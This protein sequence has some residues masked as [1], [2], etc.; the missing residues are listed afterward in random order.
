MVNFIRY[1]T[2]KLPGGTVESL[3]KLS[4]ILWIKGR[5]IALEKDHKKYGF[6]EACKSCKMNIKAKT[7][8]AL[9][10]CMKAHLLT[11]KPVVKSNIELTKPAGEMLHG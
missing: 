9:E 7:R 3:K 1:K 6:K 5:N 8:K 11:H 10:A 2:E 4:R